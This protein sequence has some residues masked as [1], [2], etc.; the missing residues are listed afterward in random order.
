MTGSCTWDALLR[1]TCNITCFR[2]RCEH[3]PAPSSKHG[4]SKPCPLVDQVVLTK[5]L[6]PPPSPHPPHPLPQSHA[7][8]CEGVSALAARVQSDRELTAL[9]R[10]KFAIKCTTG[11]WGRVCDR[12]RERGGGKG[13]WR[14]QQDQLPSCVPQVSAAAGG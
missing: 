9:I 11:E 8:L 3:T 4:L 7:G 2:F 5:L 12:E 1:L 6:P 14:G 13:Q 10:R